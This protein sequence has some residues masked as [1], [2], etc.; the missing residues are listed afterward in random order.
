MYIL[1][2]TDRKRK[3]DADWQKKNYKR[4]GVKLY[5][6]DAE[7]FE[8]LLKSQGKSVNS[9][10]R[11]YVSACLGRPLERRTAAESDDDGSDPGDPG[12]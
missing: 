8:N 6:K 5:K 1:P 4:L 2:M 10:F 3:T 7:D 11:E 9:A 12:E